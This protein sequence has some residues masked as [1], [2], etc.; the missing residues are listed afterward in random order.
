[1]E[2]AIGVLLGAIV[3]L[4][5]AATGA[6][7]LTAKRRR[8]EAF[9]LVS[10]VGG[11][12]GLEV[13]EEPLSL[14]LP[15][16]DSGAT[17]HY[18]L[19]APGDERDSI[20]LKASRDSPTRLGNL[21]VD[22]DP[23]RVYAAGMKRLA[24]GSPRFDGCFRVFTQEERTDLVANLLA[25]EEELLRGLEALA[26][27]TRTAHL[28]LQDLSGTLKIQVDDDSLR[29]P[30]DVEAVTRGIVAVYRRYRRLAGLD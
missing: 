24:L 29:F 2:T 13:R 27:H 23:V 14:V 21:M 16:D 9:Y 1:M 3:V 10:G 11:R 12:L 26:R 18:H 17:V 28:E 15:D 20:T 19:L 7:V 25:G 30:S 5:L 6:E 8:R 4:L 22:D